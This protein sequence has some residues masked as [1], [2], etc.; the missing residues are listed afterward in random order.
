MKQTLIIE[1]RLISLNE[2][3]NANRSHRNKG[4][5]LKK[6]QETIVNT[7][8]IK[9]RLEAIK[10][11]PVSIVITW[12]E[13]DNRRD[14]DNIT[15][16]VKFILDALV[17]KKILTNDSRKYVNDIRHI[18]LTDKDN[19]RIEVKIKENENE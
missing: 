4:S 7:Y 1:G 12:Y 11:Y 16:A 18:V 5:Q 9:S 6:K 13:K 3:V 17:K 15:F 2:Y 10:T 14:F 19:P 8:I